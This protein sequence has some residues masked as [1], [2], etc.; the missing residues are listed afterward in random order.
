MPRTGTAQ[1]QDP[2]D[3]SCDATQVPMIQKMQ[4]TVDILKVPHIDKEMEVLQA[5]LIDEDVEVPEIMQRHDPMIQEVEDA[6]KDLVNKAEAQLKKQRR[7]RQ[8]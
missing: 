8:L 1:W 2:G 4:K 3:V 5:Q 7:H 6:Q